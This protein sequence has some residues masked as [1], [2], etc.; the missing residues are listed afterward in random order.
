MA[1][2]ALVRKARLE[3]ARVS[4][5]DPKSGASTNSATFASAASKYNAGAPGGVYRRSSGFAFAH[6]H[7]GHL[8]QPRQ[9]FFQHE[10][11]GTIAREGCPLLWC[12]QPGPGPIRRL[13]LRQQ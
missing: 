13:R 3:L 7:P 11:Q 12:V 5:P 1:A 8:A 6:Q 9:A 4:P 10:I 2:N